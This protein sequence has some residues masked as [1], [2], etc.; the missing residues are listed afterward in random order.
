MDISYTISNFDVKNMD[1]I[2][3]IQVYMSVL[4]IYSELFI[5]I[6]KAYL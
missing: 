1:N 3:I 5:Y 4:L 6:G 2:Y